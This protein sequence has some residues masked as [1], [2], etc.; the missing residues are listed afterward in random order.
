[1]KYILTYIACFLF[2]LNSSEQVALEVS[3]EILSKNNYDISIIQVFPQEFPKVSVVFQAKNELGEPLWLLTK[4][5]LGVRE[6]AFECEILDVR[7]I[8]EKRPLNLALVFD[9]SG[10]M[11]ENPEH[12]KDNSINYQELYFLD[13]CRKVM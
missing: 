13:D 3:T 9:H 4:E 10:S 2:C 6:N 7:N 1:M 11:I 12:M 8:S 5:E